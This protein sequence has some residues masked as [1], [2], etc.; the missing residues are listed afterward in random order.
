MPSKKVNRRQFI[1][2]TGAVGV[3][4]AAL[5]NGLILPAVAKAASPAK[6]PESVVKDLY[7]SFTEQ[8]RKVVCFDWDHQDAKRG[9]LRTRVG[10]NW[11]ITAP[12]LRGQKKFYTDDQFDMVRKIFEG[13]ISPDWHANFDKQLKDD[14]GGFGH[15]QA[16]AIFG[17]PGDGKFEFVLTGRHM[18]MRCDGNSAEHVAFGGPIFYGHAGEDAEEYPDHPGNVF[19]GQALEANKVY[20]MLDGK[21]RKL[22]EVAKSPAE[23][24]IQFSGAKGNRTGI[25]AS[26]LSG[27]QKEHLQKVLQKLIEPY[28]QDDRDEVVSCLKKQG[29]IDACNLSFFTDKDI[30]KDR[31]WDNW[32]LEGPSFVWH[33]RGAPHVHVWVNVADNA[34][35]K[36]NS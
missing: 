32:R 12:S 11:K 13:L 26:E 35:V 18:T 6:T 3:G 33:F 5:S 1:A 24:K 34:S 28:R 19:W 2:S 27:D 17:K 10:A 20:Q 29:G 14:A 36:T 9:N 31:V 4:A 23:S 16:I 21:Q 30:G 25:P 22:A 7:N 15:D 8:Q